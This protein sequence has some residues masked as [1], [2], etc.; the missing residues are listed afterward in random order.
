ML[1]LRVLILLFL[2]SCVADTGNK[3]LVCSPGESFDVKL[4]KCIKLTLTDSFKIKEAETKNYIV[5]ISRLTDE[6]PVECFVLSEGEGIDVSCVCSA[7]RCQ[8]LVSPDRSYKWYPNFAGDTYF[9]YRL[10]DGVGYSSNMLVNVL[11]SNTPDA[12]IANDQTFTMNE[13]SIL[14][15]Y[16]DYLDH[17]GDVDR[18]EIISPPQ[19]GLASINSDGTFTYIPDSGFDGLDSFEY[20]V[21]DSSH[22][23]TAIVSINVIGVYD[24]PYVKSSELAEL[25]NDLNNNPSNS[26]WVQGGVKEDGHFSVTLPYTELD[27]NQTGLSCNISVI[28]PAVLNITRA[29]QCV[30]PAGMTVAKCS[31]DFEVLKNKY[32]SVQFSYRVTTGNTDPLSVASTPVQFVSFVIDEVNDRPMP[33]H[34]FAQHVSTDSHNALI[35]TAFTLPVLSTD[36]DSPVMDNPINYTYTVETLPTKGTLS[37][38]L[39]GTTLNLSARCLY[40]PT[41]STKIANPWRQASAYGAGIKFVAKRYG[42]FGN[43]IVIKFIDNPDIMPGG[44]FIEVDFY[45]KFIFIYIKSINSTPLDIYNTLINSEEAMSLVDVTL[46]DTSTIN[47]PVSGTSLTLNGATEGLD[48]VSFKVTDTR[49]GQSFSSGDIYFS[50][51]NVY[52]TPAYIKTESFV[53]SD[54]VVADTYEF[55]LDS[56]STTYDLI[57]PITAGTLEGC[58]NGTTLDRSVKCR[59]T[60]INGEVFGVYSA[61]N[62][63]WGDLSFSARRLGT[64]GNDIKIIFSDSSVAGSE[65]ALISG[66]TI[67]VVME[68]NVSSANAIKAAIENS[69]SAHGLVNV[70]VSG[71]GNNAQSVGTFTLSGGVNGITS[72]RYWNAASRYLGIVYI[73]I[74]ETADS[75]TKVFDSPRICRYS[76]AYE[77][78]ECG[79]NGCIGDLNP[80]EAGITPRKE[81]LFYYYKDRLDV[82]EGGD[83]GAICYVSTGTSSV[84]DWSVI[85]TPSPERITIHINEQDTALIKRVRLD[86][87]G[88]EDELNATSY[89]GHTY[90]NYCQITS[91]S[92]SD[93]ILLPLTP[94]NIKIKYDTNNDGDVTDFG[95]HFYTAGVINPN[96]VSI[97][98]KDIWVEMIPAKAK[99][100]S[101]DV[102]ITFSCNRPDPNMLQPDPVFGDFLDVATPNG[103]EVVLKFKLQVHE[104]SIK[105]NGWKNIMALGP[106][107]NHFGYAMDYCQYDTYGCSSGECLGDA[108]PVGR[109]TPS[110]SDLIYFNSNDGKCYISTGTSF[111]DWEQANC[112]VSSTI[113]EP[114][115]NGSNTT[116][117]KCVGS[118]SPS[119]VVSASKVNSYYYDSTNDV[120][121]RSKAVGNNWE[122]YKTPA[123]VILEWESFSILSAGTSIQGYNVFRRSFGEE[124]DYERPINRDLISYNTTKYEDNNNNSIHA[125]IP[126]T[127]YFYDVRPVMGGWN[128]TSGS[129]SLQI[130][131]VI[132]PPNNM[133]YVPRRI[134]NKEVCQLLGTNRTTIEKNHHNRCRYTG[135][136]SISIDSDQD[137]VNEGYY[138]IG[139]DMLV[140][141]FEAG[142]PYGLSPACNGHEEGTCVGNGSPNDLGVNAVNGTY[143]YDRKVGICYQK[144]GGLWKMKLTGTVPNYRTASLP[145]LTRYNQINAN[146]FCSDLPPLSGIVGLDGAFGLKLPNRKEQIGYSKWDDSYDDLEVTAIEEGLDLNSSAK[147]NSSFADGVDDHFVD[148]HVPPAGVHYTLPGTD[149]SGIRSLVTGS[150]KT[151]V[152]QSRF[153]IQDAIGNVNEWIQDRLFCMTPMTCEIRTKELSF[154]LSSY[155]ELGCDFSAPGVCNDGGP[156]LCYGNTDPTTAG[157]SASFVGAVFY[158]VDSG[159]CYQ[160]DGAAWGN[161]SYYSRA[162]PQGV[163]GTGT[164]PS[165]AQEAWTRMRGLWN[166]EYD[167]AGGSVSPE[168]CNDTLGG[169]LPCA[170]PGS[171]V[172]TTTGADA[173]EYI[174]LDTATKSFYKSFDVDDATAFVGPIRPVYFLPLALDTS[175]SM[176]VPRDLEYRVTVPLASAGND[177]VD[178]N[179][180]FYIY[181]FDGVRGPCRDSS[182]TFNCNLPMQGWDLISPPSSYRAVNFIS[183][184]G[185]PVARN[186]DFTYVHPYSQE[187]GMTSGI[188]SGKLHNDYF[189]VDTK[190]IYTGCDYTIGGCS[191]GASN[192]FDCIGDDPVGVINPT[193]VGV[194]YFDSVNNTCYESIGVSA[195]SWEVIPTCEFTKDGCLDLMGNVIDCTAGALYGLIPEDKA[196]T[197]GVTYLDN[198]SGTPICFHASPCIGDL[199]GPV[200]PITG[201]VVGAA[202][203]Y[204][205]D[206]TDNQCYLYDGVTWVQRDTQWIQGSQN[207]CG[208]LLAGGDY[209]N[210]TKNGQYSLKA[211]RCDDTQTRSEKIGFRCLA[212]I[213]YLAPTFSS[214]LTAFGKRSAAIPRT[215][216]FK[217]T[218]AVPT[219]E[220]E[221]IIQAA[222]TACF[223]LTANTCSGANLLTE[224][225]CMIVL[226]FEA[227]PANIDCPDGFHEAFIRLKGDFGQYD[228][229]ITG[230]K[231]P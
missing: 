193:A 208:S 71:T 225:T 101:S 60:P 25:I 141:R 29:C 196:I 130:I 79:K 81:G 179:R 200:D 70:T 163:L 14:T 104:A 83:R 195:S 23:D 152:C 161:V 52:D 165:F 205:R 64:Y 22:S 102:D 124:F 209:E 10:F 44:E 9:I 59:Y 176:I 62:Y 211:M 57:D 65:Y 117:T 82:G 134:V 68:N 4:R 73:N 149:S 100:G 38:C 180:N 170:G 191:V 159:L 171:P 121:Y 153:G 226:Q 26:P 127:V 96:A 145:P 199:S 50:S 187:I 230:S 120:C 46:V 204:Y 92:S 139:Y 19:H 175:A 143:F 186:T 188:E 113:E 189:D 229:R 93:Q 201:G 88:G 218:D 72:F 111:Q 206:E 27:G 132:V 40:R 166:F 181:R 94:N 11:V 18:V 1:I 156:T 224:Q 31:A 220:I 15:T 133:A 177:D 97:D 108:S 55:N 147:C 216:T 39:N 45:N 203:D 67:T 30:V 21:S 99:F 89:S 34:F 77:A 155:D 222:P 146:N 12:P 136:G 116:I 42:A 160:W 154:E 98:S 142:C 228:V 192:A 105:H 87:G 122:T 28:T 125:P 123:R 210:G 114:N 131:R 167:G 56:T 115:C 13:N 32:G 24:D 16:L 66:K 63:T 43:G 219:G 174:Y 144:E 119:G 198:L 69:P 212:Q 126:N 80:K 150:E 118:G 202:G 213:P 231:I 53:E 36:V 61:A 74:T 182:G 48:K 41:D 86:E 183:P 215:Y 47:N 158:E 137:G 2:I 128:A 207:G 75:N 223:S 168:P 7:G 172:V 112:N 90:D 35:E 227:D 173:S 17:D 217:N 129:E 185:I 138:D 49:G 110:Q 85:T 84:N 37:G 148:A 140:D 51:Q 157:L 169:E 5:P 107:V 78:P 197:A 162:L 194:K 106:K 214:T 95:D 151:N 164:D 190:N 135:P 184:V 178:F 8:A 20:I 54:T 58:L 76:S 91:I 109:I 6:I 221:T 103:T 3:D 33:L